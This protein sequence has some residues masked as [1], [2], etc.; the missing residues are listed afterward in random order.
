MVLSSHNSWTYLRPQK[1]W[2]YLIRF[3]AKCQ[4]ED[5]VEQFLDGARCFDLRIKFNNE[6]ELVIAHGLVKYK[7][8]YRRLINDLSWLDGC[9]K[10]DAKIYVRILHEIRKESEYSDKKVTLF[11]NFCSYIEKMCPNIIFFGGNNLIN[12]SQDY[13]FGNNISIED[14]YASVACPK[15]GW[16]PWLYAKFM[17]KK[18]LKADTDKDV[19][20]ID[21]VD[22][23]K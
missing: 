4:R 8:S 6:R 14:G 18:Y 2:M 20:M 3:T 11:K 10:D 5:V 21:F 7:Y 13:D 12:C 19:L 9:A 16:W 1:M 23:K 15:L 17:N 22:I